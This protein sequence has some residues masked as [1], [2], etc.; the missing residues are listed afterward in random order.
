MRI[1]SSRYFFL[2]TLLTFLFCCSH[3]ANS[4][5]LITNIC[6]KTLN[7]TYCLQ[8]LKPLYRSGDSLRDLAKDTID[9]SSKFL[10]FVYDEIHVR[11]IQS[12]KNTV[13]NDIY[14][15]CGVQ[16]TAATNAIR[17]GQN[18]LGSGDY[19]N[20]SSLAALALKQAQNCELNFGG[21][22]SEPADF[23]NL[24][25]KGRDVCSIV[26]AVANLLV[27]RKI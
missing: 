16:Y 11:E 20:L 19:R 22:V 26:L 27:S 1:F 25:E 24:N 8:F 14:H 2:F 10:F 15:K 17:K 4:P 12:S 3:A 13:L 18:A 6:S 5:D 9:S 23:K 21:G 7:P